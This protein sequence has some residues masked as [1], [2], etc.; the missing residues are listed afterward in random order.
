[1]YCPSRNGPFAKSLR[2]AQNVILEIQSCIDACPGETGM[3]TII[4]S[5][6][7]EQNISSVNGQYLALSGVILW[8]KHEKHVLLLLRFCDILDF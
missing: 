8:K 7:L 1:M 2:H 6:D 5:L 3:V 4:A